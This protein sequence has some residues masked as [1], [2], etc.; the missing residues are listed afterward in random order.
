MVFG[1]KDLLDF[2]DIFCL[3]GPFELFYSSKGILISG[4]FKLDLPLKGFVLILST[5][6]K[7]SGAAVNL[8][9]FN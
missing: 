3:K 1:D 2:D 5:L 9:K 6:L 4:K 7:L 8:S